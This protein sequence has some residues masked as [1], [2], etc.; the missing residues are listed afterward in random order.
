MGVVSHLLSETQAQGFIAETKAEYV[1]L[2]ER[3][4]RRQ[5]QVEFLPLAQ[6]RQRKLRLIG[7]SKRL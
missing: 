5:K 6:A 2:R 1:K 7:G 4:E 3:H